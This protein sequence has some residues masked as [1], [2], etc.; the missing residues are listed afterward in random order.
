MTDS[1]ELVR[2]RARRVIFEMVGFGGE[3]LKAIR[4]RRYDMVIVEHER[5]IRALERLLC[6]QPH[7]GWVQIP[8][9]ADKAARDEILRERA[10]MITSSRTFKKNLDLLRV[11]CV[12]SSNEQHKAKG[13][14]YTVEVFDRPKTKV[15]EGA[16]FPAPV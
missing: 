12:V 14:F 5:L 10:E 13:T 8:K 3:A 4:N 11:L 9:I 7:M 16:S 1:W 2:C 15:T 6:I